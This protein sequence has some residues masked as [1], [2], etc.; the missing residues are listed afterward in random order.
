MFLVA[1]ETKQCLFDVQANQPGLKIALFVSGAAIVKSTRPGQPAHRQHY[2]QTALL[3][4]VKRSLCVT[5]QRRTDRC[6][7]CQKIVSI[8]SVAP[9]DTV[10]YVHNHIVSFANSIGALAFSVRSVPCSTR[11]SIDEMMMVSKHMLILL[12]IGRRILFEFLRRR[13]NNR[14]RRPRRLGRLGRT[15]FRNQLRTL[16][17]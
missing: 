17:Q 14:A 16:N 11:P 2:T 5:A 7:S 9:P 10:P 12:D 13:E 3:C 1:F 15:R 6:G 4:L 8:T